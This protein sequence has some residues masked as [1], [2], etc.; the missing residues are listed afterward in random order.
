MGNKRIFGFA[1]VLLVTA[2]ILHA[3]ELKFDGYLNSGLGVVSSGQE[4]SD[5]VMRAFG[6]DSEQ[7]GYRFRFNGA[8]SSEDQSAGLR[9]RFQSQAR[10]DQGGYFSLPYVYGWLKFLNDIFYL[11]GGIVDDTGMQTADW[12]I[13]DDVGE[14]LG[15]LLK[16]APVKGLE[17]G[18]GAYVI[19]QQSAGANNILNVRSTSYLSLPNF[20]NIVPKIGDVKYTYSA[21]YTAPDIFRAGAS[22]RWKNKAGWNGTTDIEYLGYIYDGRQE[23]AQLIGEFRYLGT[24][25]L[26]AVAAVNLDK[27]EAFDTEGDMVFSETFAYRLDNAAFGLDAVQFLYNRKYPFGRK[28]DCDPGLLFN[29]WGSYAVNRIVPRLDLVY[30]LGGRSQEGL[31]YHRRGFVNAESPKN[32]NDDRSVFSFRPSVRFN[33]NPSVFIEAGDLFNYDYAKNK[34]FASKLYG[35]LDTNSRISNVFY[36]DVKWAF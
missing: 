19:S 13:N 33:L 9:F 21:S 11:A 24:E 35:R 2:G 5:T 28:I 3:Q 7:Q 29:L 14:G 31:V 32:V 26:T 17:L 36:V 12:W 18:F 10:L 34:A 4:G 8:F 22:F 15:M 23:S 27:L 20:G 25:N 6:V 16:A 30:F 1:A